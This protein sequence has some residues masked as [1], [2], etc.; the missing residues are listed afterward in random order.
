MDPQAGAGPTH[1]LFLGHGVLAAVAVFVVEARRR[2][3]VDEKVVYVVLGALVGGAVCMRLAL[4][5][6]AATTFG[7]GCGCSTWICTERPEHIAVT[8]EPTQDHGHSRGPY[9][10][11]AC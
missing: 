11:T 2:G 4:G 7:T 8:G 9:L 5:W 3:Q 1:P 6:A 10:G